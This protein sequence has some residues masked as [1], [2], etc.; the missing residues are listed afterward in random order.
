MPLTPK[1]LRFIDE[2]LIDLNAT[3]AYKRAG[4]SARGN[5]AETNAARLLRNAQVAAILKKRQ[6]AQQE[7]TGITADNALKEIARIAFMDVRKLFNPD[8]SL[9]PISELDDD[10]AAFVAGLD[11]VET[12]GKEPETLKRIKLR[13]KLGALELLGKHLGIFKEHIEIENKG[14]VLVVPGGISADDWESLAAKQQT[15][16]KA[17]ELKLASRKT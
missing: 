2:Y 3:A 13:D 8:G 4:Y 12:G 1:Q 7:R 5:A 10:A 11:V 16:L 17:K 9:K 14:G 15:E 6:E